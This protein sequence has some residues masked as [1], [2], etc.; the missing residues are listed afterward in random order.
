[1]ILLKSKGMNRSLCVLS[2]HPSQAG[3]GFV[4]ACPRE[5]H[6]QVGFD[7]QIHISRCNFLS[8]KRAQWL[9]RFNLY[10]RHSFRSLS[11]SW[12]LVKVGP[13]ARSLAPKFSLVDCQSGKPRR[14]GGGRG[15]RTE[16]EFGG[17]EPKQLT[18][19]VS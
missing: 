3:L 4:L 18:V 7:F 16:E 2:P 13:S 1:M 8:R 9:I 17:Q 6:R 10:R 5:C 15:R 14:Q 11:C 19:K 12:G